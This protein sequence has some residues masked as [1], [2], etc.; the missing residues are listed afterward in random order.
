M[1]DVAVNGDDVTL[2]FQTASLLVL[3]AAVIQRAT[4][5]Q[6]LLFQPLTFVPRTITATRFGPSLRAH[7]II[8]AFG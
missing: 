3:E 1:K 4:A 7:A 2:S 6:G 8:K 5:C